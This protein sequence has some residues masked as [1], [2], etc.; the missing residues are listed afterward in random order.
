MNANLLCCVP[1]TLD[2]RQVPCSRGAVQHRQGRAGR[3]YRL[4]QRGIR[5]HV[6][7]QVCLQSWGAPPGCIGPLP[8]TGRISR[9]PH[10]KEL[11]AW[12]LVES[13]VCLPIVVLLLM[14]LVTIPRLKRGSSVSCNCCFMRESGT[15]AHSPFRLTLTLQ[16]FTLF[17][18]ALRRQQREGSQRHAVS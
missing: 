3:L 8:E 4:F 2:L 5:C 9:S 15:L 13:R 12:P 1:P 7:V 14:F 11:T 10:C 18:Q 16:V 17:T 6:Q